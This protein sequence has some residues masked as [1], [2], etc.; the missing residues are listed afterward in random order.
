MFV[1]VCVFVYVYMGAYTFRSEDDLWELVL[2]VHHR[3]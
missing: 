2:S 3:S 1:L